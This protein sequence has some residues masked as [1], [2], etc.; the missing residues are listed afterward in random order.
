MLSQNDQTPDSS[1]SDNNLMNRSLD[2]MILTI[3]FLSAT[4]HDGSLK[5]LTSLS[6]SSSQNR[7]EVNSSIDIILQN[8]LREQAA[9]E[10]LKIQNFEIIS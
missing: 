1:G 7:S 3:S 4:L 2:S 6:P 9:I 8:L 10:N 5:S